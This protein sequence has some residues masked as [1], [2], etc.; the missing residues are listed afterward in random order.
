[1]RFVVFVSLNFTSSYVFKVVWKPGKNSHRWGDATGSR[2]VLLAILLK[3]G[4]F[5]FHGFRERKKGLKIK[6]Y[7]NLQIR[8]TCQHVSLDDVEVGP[9]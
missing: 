2:S 3:E 7:T 5:F 6:I 8:R 4:S 1:M 9:L